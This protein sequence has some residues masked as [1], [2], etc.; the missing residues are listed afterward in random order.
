MT[1]KSRAGGGF[2]LGDKNWENLE[3]EDGIEEIEWVFISGVGKGMC[4]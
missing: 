2:N 4:S 1:P 3:G